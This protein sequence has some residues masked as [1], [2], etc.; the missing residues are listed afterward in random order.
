MVQPRVVLGGLFAALLQVGCGVGSSPGLMPAGRRL[1]AGRDVSNVIWT[2]QTLLFTRTAGLGDPARPF[3]LWRWNGGDAEPQLA[4]ANLESPSTGYPTWMWSPDFLIPGD[5]ST[6]LY[7]VSTDQLIETGYVPI[8]VLKRDGLALAYQPLDSTGVSVIG[9]FGRVDLQGLDAAAFD[10]VGDDLLVLGRPAGSTDAYDLF[11]VSLP[12]GGVTLAGALALPTTF[13]RIAAS[14]SSYGGAPCGLFQVI[15]CD[16]PGLSP[17]F[18]VYARPDGAGGDASVPVA[19][20]LLTGSE[21]ALAGLG[22]FGRFTPS[23][24]R[25]RVAWQEVAA[26]GTAG[27]IRYWDARTGASGSCAVPGANQII[28]SPDGSRLAA[29]ATAAN[30]QLG[31]VGVADSSCTLPADGTR[32]S[33]ADFTPAG[34]WVSWLQLSLSPGDPPTTV[35]LATGDGQNAR[36]VASDERLKGRYFSVGGSRLFL[37][38]AVDSRTVISWIEVND[39][40]AT[41]TA[42]TGA[43]GAVATGANRFLVTGDWNDQ[44]G[45]GTL[46]LVSFDAS[47]PI[48]VSASVPAFAA[49]GPVD[50]PVPLAYT[51]RTRFASPADGLWALTL[52]P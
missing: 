51:V 26:D 36:A 7:Q 11:R 32:V 9:P 19:F 37:V 47:A 23:R 35:W 18:V 24:D 33:R 3:D 1:L 40:T 17:C 14:C 22:P 16:Q 28:W 20:D 21:S 29:D 50:Q 42:W 13:T 6:T 5:Q 27:D 39:P 8:R 12:D 48:T 41:E 43:V 2:G 10:Y 15:G 49:G 44:D 31:L 38:R 30:G 4:V 46:Q 34:E 52:P 45:V 25:T